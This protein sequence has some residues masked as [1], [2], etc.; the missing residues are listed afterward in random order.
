MRAQAALEY[1]M[2]Y[3]W[4]LLIVVIVGVALWS[5][6]VF[7]VGAGNVIRLTGVNSLQLIDANATG[8]SG[9]QNVTMIVSVRRPVTNAAI[10]LGGVSCTLSDTNMN[11]G[12]K[13]TVTCNNV[14]ITNS[15]DI[16]FDYTDQYSG[17]THSESGSLIGLAG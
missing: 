3:G 17:M 2:T 9:A 6:G 4:A 8:T 7:N 1:L 11:P 15:I 5:L 13:Y 10:T 12:K 14:D 16:T